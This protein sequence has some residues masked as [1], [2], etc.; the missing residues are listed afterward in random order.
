MLSPNFNR[1]GVLTALF[2]GFACDASAEPTQTQHEAHKLIRANDA[3]G[4]LGNDLFG[5]E[6]NLYSG[7]LEF[8]AVDVSLPGNDDLPMQIARRFSVESI[9]GDRVVGGLFG[10]WEMDLPMIHGTFSNAQGFSVIGVNTAARCS[11]FDAPPPAHGDLDGTFNAEEFW[12]GTSLYVPGVGDQPIL[13]RGSNSLAPGGN[14][15]GYPLVTKNHWQIACTV[16]LNPSTGTGEGF[17]VLSPSGVTYRFDWLTYRPIK[18]ITKPKSTS[19]KAPEQSVLSRKE[20]RLYPTL[21]TD[22][23]GN[24]V[25]LGW[26]GAQLQSMSASDG[27]SLTITYVPGTNRIQKV[28]D[29]SRYWNYIYDANKHLDSVVRP[30][31]SNWS[32]DLAPLFNAWIYYYSAGYCN[33]GSM[34]TTGFTGSITHPSGARGSFSVTPTRHGRSYVPYACA[35]TG[36]SFG[37]LSQPDTFDTLAL[38]GKQISGADFQPIAWD[39]AYSPAEPCFVQ[40]G[41]QTPPSVCAEKASTTKTVTVTKTVGNPFPEYQTRQFTFGTQFEVDEGQLLIDQEGAGAAK[42]TTVLTYG[43][44]VGPVPVGNPINHRGDTQMTTRIIPQTKSTATIDANQYV[45]Q[46]TTWDAYGNP[47]TVTRSGPTASKTETTTYAPNTTKWILGLTDQVKDLSTN[48]V[49]L[50]LDYDTSGRPVQRTVLGRI[51][52]SRA[53]CTAVNIPTGCTAADKNLLRWVADGGGK[54]T[55]FSNYKRGI[56]QLVKFADNRTI[57]GVVNDLGWV[58]SY[59]DEL[60]NTTG[61]SFDPLGR[62]KGVNQPWDPSIAWAPTTITFAKASAAQY[63][64]SAN[65]WKQSI[66][67]GNYR[68]ETLFDGLWRPIVTH[69]WD[70]AQGGDRFTVRRFDSEGRGT[71]TSFPVGSV[72]NHA[73]VLSGSRNF[74][75][76]TGRLIRSESDFE[77]GVLESKISYL[78]GARKQVTNPNGNVTETTYQQLDDA[79]EA[80]P[81]QII[82]KQGTT[83]TLANV[84]IVRDVWGKPKSVT[85][86]GTAPAVS[87]TRTYVYDSNQRLCKLIEPERGAEV[88]HYDGSNN[89]DWTAKG[90]NLLNP[91][92]CNTTNVSYS[93][94][95]GRTYDARNRLTMIDYPD[96][97]LDEFRTYEADGA[98]DTLTRGSTT[99]GDIKSS[100]DYNARRLPTS[101]TIDIDTA[102]AGGA[103]SFGYVYDNLGNLRAQSTLNGV[104]LDYNPN[105]LGQPTT[106]SSPTDRVNTTFAYNI[107]WFPNG[108]LKGFTYGNGVVHTLTQNTRG[109]PLRS[110]DKKGTSAA[111]VDFTNTFDNNGNPVSISDAVGYDSKSMIYDGLDRL[112]SASGAFGSATYEYDALDNLTRNKINSRDWRYA[113]GGN[114]RLDRINNASGQGQISFAHDARGNITEKYLHANG[115][116]AAFGFDLAERLQST[117]RDGALV[118]NYRYDGHGRRVKTT[119]A[120]GDMQFQVYQLDGQYQWN[121]QFVPGIKET[122]TNNIYVAGSMIAKFVSETTYSQAAQASNNSKAGEGRSSFDPFGFHYVLPTGAGASAKAGGVTTTKVVYIHTDALGSPVAE[123]NSA[124]QFI[125]DSRAFYEPYGNPLS[126]PTD[127]SPSYTGHPFDTATGLVYAQQRYYDPQMGRFLSVDPMAADTSSAFNFNRYNYANNS[128]YRYV[129]PD[130]RYGTNLEL[131][132][133]CNETGTC[134]TVEEAD[135]IVARD[136]RFLVGAQLTI[137]GSATGIVGGVRAAP[138]VIAVAKPYL[139]KKTGKALVCAALSLGCKDKPD[140]LTEDLKRQAERLAELQYGRLRKEPSPFGPPPPKPRPEPKPGAPSPP[141]TPRP[142]PVPPKPE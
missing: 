30:D 69:E 89:V 139:T 68:K 12:N 31:G 46:T 122:H 21:I 6:V 23:F 74:F 36:P 17:S 25:T 127:G 54:K 82:S 115:M 120:N 20:A 110:L 11:S 119:K 53:Y 80:L 105:A 67:T 24:T 132:R 109:L 38:T 19:T 137:A 94:M 102:V 112:K 56:P 79:S 40:S 65:H 16:P 78:A 111:I 86:S 14:L 75:D 63:G 141:P 9:G 28:F 135:E 2:L 113:I 83:T 91:T 58:T 99:T 118:A 42:R 97:T 49:E 45:R 44:P 59:T 125:V 85:R 130:G 29:G 136:A 123:S 71:F 7:A 138:V 64:L 13:E 48:L 22:R 96:E 18:G 116:T 131:R 77:F 124:G 8:G 50:D 95:I 129:D 43:A 61:Y 73:Q 133:S 92:L 47:T 114:Q 84:A 4:A 100:Y 98:L 34:A 126:T 134:L 90:L 26:V 60:G 108:A 10:D 52:E 72:T 1:L 15:M 35:T 88:Y 128:P 37:H 62:L 33:P 106:V 121:A 57:S 32:Y 3:I 27:R 5:E 87:A 70:S 76:E 142:D 51:D 103:S 93:A 66:S 81:T 107:S 104:W 41:R 140:E 101:E 117:S 55:T 39:Y